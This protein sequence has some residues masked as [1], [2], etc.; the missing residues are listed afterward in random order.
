MHRHYPGKVCTRMFT[1]NRMHYNH[2]GDK[3]NSKKIAGDIL[4]SDITRDSAGGC[5]VGS[6]IMPIN[7]KT[8]SEK[9]RDR[10]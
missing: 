2:R 8:K 3:N 1:E 5:G 10:V 6:S 4:G 7:C 9:P